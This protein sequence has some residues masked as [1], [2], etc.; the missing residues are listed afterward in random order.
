MRCFWRKEVS[1]IQPVT[2]V[3]FKK[4]MKE[5]VGCYY[6][7]SFLRKMR[8]VMLSHKC[9]LVD[10]RISSSQHFTGKERKKQQ[11][12]QF[13]KPL[14]PRNKEQHFQLMRP[15]LHVREP[16]GSREKMRQ[17]ISL[18]LVPRISARPPRCQLFSL[19]STLP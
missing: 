5:G 14:C 13:C 9:R 11:A 18:V 19:V 6:V 2:L 15:P 4:C 16:N 12:K 10:C 7:P 3:A 1:C 8:I 17:N